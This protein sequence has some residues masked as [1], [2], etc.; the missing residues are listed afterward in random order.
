MSKSTY[1]ALEGNNRPVRSISI[2][3][4]SV[5]STVSLMVAFIMEILLIAE[6]LKINPYD[7]DAVEDIKRN[8]IRNLKKYE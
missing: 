7:Q 8:T 4:I 6:L 3:D 1:Q 5:E 2:S